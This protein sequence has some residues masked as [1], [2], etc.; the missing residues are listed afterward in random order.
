MMVLRCAPGPEPHVAFEIMADYYDFVTVIKLYDPVSVRQWI[1]QVGKC[2]SDADNSRAS[3]LDSLR[4]LLTAPFPIGVMKARQNDMPILVANIDEP[5][6][7]F[8]RRR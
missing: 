5:V 2:Q 4:Y 7:E 6:S 3:R 1:V 8:V